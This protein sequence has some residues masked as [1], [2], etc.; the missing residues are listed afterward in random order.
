MIPRGS[1]LQWVPV[2]EYEGLEIREV[3]GCRKRFYGIGRA[4]KILGVNPS[5]LWLV[6]TGKRQ[7]S[8]LLAR[9]RIV[10]SND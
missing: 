5:H 9:I 7:S 6:L 10:K 1:F 3:N 8:R 4:A 2:Q